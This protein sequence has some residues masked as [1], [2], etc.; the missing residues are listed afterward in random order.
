METEYKDVNDN[1]IQYEG[2][3]NLNNNQENEPITGLGLDEKI[4]NNAG[5]R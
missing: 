3:G 2:T 1:R 5:D 4:G